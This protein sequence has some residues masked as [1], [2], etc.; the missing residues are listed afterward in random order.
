[1]ASMLCEWGQKI[2]V[3][4]LNLW[5]T[6]L[7]FLCYNLKDLVMGTISC[8]FVLLNYLAAALA[9][10]QCSFCVPL[11]SLLTRPDRPW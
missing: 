1:M 3:L 5:R 8:I 9:L 11:A 7:K 10:V 4:G 2:S 6:R